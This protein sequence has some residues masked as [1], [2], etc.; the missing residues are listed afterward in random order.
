MTTHPR[1]LSSKIAYHGKLFDVELDKLQMP[2]GVVT[3][4]E[5]VRHPGA[6][7]MVPVDADGRLVLVTQYRH[8][9]G[10]RLLELPA[11]TLEPGEEP[12]LTAVRELQEEIGMRPGKVEALGGFFVAPGYT[13]EY[14]WLFV[15]TD[16][17]PARLDGDDD[18]DIE[19][20]R[21]TVAEA[22]A[23]IESGGICDAKSVVGILRWLQSINR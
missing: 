18:E 6:V 22:L 1:L 12:G 7:C 4:R 5:I 9:A 21:A 13:T 10:K 20:E 3:E 2:G 16:L 14:I 17:V 15:C 8:A 11:G 19:V 23:A